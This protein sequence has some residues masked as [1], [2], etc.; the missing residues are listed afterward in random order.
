[1]RPAHLVARFFESLRAG[2]LDAADLAWV[3]AALEPAELRVWN[4]MNDADR[5]EG[6]AVARRLDDV[7]ANQTDAKGATGTTWRAAAL[8]HDAGKQLSAYGTIG[9]A[10]V[11]VVATVAG[12]GRAREWAGS[13][14][15]I[16]GR[17]G[18]Y[19]AHDD[20]GAALLRDMGARAE[21][22][23]WAEAHHR[24]ERWAGTGIPPAVCRALAAADGESTQP[25]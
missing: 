15:P 19:V 5:A 18:R 8:L 11:T 10:A 13:A 4:G 3:T 23:A 25:D 17:M 1:M 9:R 14:R 21:V 6:A 24:P 20:L 12:K 7:L 16:V 2:P 22:A